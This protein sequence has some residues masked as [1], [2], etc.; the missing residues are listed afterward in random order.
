MAVLFFPT[1]LPTACADLPPNLNANS[2]PI[3]KTQL[4][5]RAELC[6]LMLNILLTSRCL[7]EGQVIPQ[8]VSSSPNVKHQLF[9]LHLSDVEGQ[10]RPFKVPPSYGKCDLQLRAQPWDTRAPP[11]TPW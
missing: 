4:Q 5:N 1:T 8:P 6:L 2:N 3:N 9:E 7:A 10:P 11:P